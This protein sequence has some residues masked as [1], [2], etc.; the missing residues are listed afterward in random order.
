MKGRD[1]SGVGSG[2]EARAWGQMGEKPQ[3]G[4][5]HKGCD[6]VSSARPATGWGEGGR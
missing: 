6:E 3:H 5:L 2:L 4:M 1:R